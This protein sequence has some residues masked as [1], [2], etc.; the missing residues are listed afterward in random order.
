MP[1]S[2]SSLARNLVHKLQNGDIDQEKLSQAQNHQILLSQAM[3]GYIEWLS[4]QLDNL[5]PQLAEAFIQTRTEAIR[6][7]KD[8][9]GRLNEAIS[10]LHIGLNALVMF[11]V[12]QEVL[13][14]DDGEKILKDAWE[15]F[16]QIADDQTRLEKAGDPSHKIAEAALELEAQRRIY[17]AD[18]EDTPVFLDRAV[19]V[20]WKDETKGIRYTNLG[21]LFR[22]V[23]QHLR[24]QDE[25]ISL[26]KNDFI[27]YLRQKDLLSERDRDKNQLRDQKTIYISSGAKKEKKRAYAISEAFFSWEAED[28]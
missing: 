25:F 13:S 15:I 9:H 21:T 19:K 27:E 20:G 18:M 2:G 26:S 5:P 16:N 8:R 11:A 23:A 22:E 14:R 6:R 1:L 4:P 17:W 10:H 7:G 24:G 12:S 3:R 28:E